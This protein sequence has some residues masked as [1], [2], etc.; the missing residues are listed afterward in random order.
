MA[1]QIAVRLDTS[2][3]IKAVWGNPVKGKGFQKQAEESEVALLSGLGAEATQPNIYED[4][5]Q[6][7]EYVNVFNLIL[8]SFFKKDFK[9]SDSIFSALTHWLATCY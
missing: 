9:I 2:S 6:Q 5:F 3:H 8:F 4:G 1:Y 7:F